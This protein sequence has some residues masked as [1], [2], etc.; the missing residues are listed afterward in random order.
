[1]ERIAEGLP[2]Q[3]ALPRFEDGAI[4]MQELIRSLAEQVANGIMNLNLNLPQFR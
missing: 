2:A 3:C 1:M 4:N